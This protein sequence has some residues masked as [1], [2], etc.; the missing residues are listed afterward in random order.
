MA[1]NKKINKKVHP[2]Y[3]YFFS[4]PILCEIMIEV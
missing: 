2:Y 3:V 4:L 1:F